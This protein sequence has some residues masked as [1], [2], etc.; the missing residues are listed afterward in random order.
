MHLDLQKFEITISERSGLGRVVDRERGGLSLRRFHRS[1]V[2][3][4]SEYNHHRSGT[5]HDDVTAAADAGVVRQGAACRLRR[6]QFGAAAWIEHLASQQF[7][8]GQ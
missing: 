5:S 1:Y 4:R 7:T 6:A 8:G 2:C 3:D